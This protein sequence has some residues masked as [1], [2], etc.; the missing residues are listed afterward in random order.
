M[1]SNHIANTMSKEG[2]GRLRVRE[3]KGERR[4]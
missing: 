2:K 3:N 4:K 1:N